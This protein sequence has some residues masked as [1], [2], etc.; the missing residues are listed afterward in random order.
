L[1][2]EEFSKATGDLLRGLP[3]VITTLEAVKVA[4][5][6]RDGLWLEFGVASGHSLTE[7]AS[8]KGSARLV[9]FDWFQGLPSNWR[10]GYPAGM[11]AC[12]VP[13]VDGVEIIQGLFEES[14]PRFEFSPVALVH[15]DCDLYLSAR[16]ALRYV[17][18]HLVAG[19]V[20]MFDELET[21]GATE[22]ELDALKDAVDAGFEYDWVAGGKATLR[23]RGPFTF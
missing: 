10:P 17:G 21:E 9:G 18:P 2:R 16:T 11:F 4:N 15:I 14:L 3:F 5:P 7:L 19:A 23:A 12:E 8:V 20:I 6:K 13:R 1:T 22:H